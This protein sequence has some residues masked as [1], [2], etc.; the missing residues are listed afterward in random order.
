[1]LQFYEYWVRDYL[2]G[3]SLGGFDGF[4]EGLNDVLFKCGFS[5]LYAGNPYDWLFLY[6]SACTTED[7]TPLDRFRGIMAQD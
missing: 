6:C 5:P 2:D 7:Y 3:R 4:I 1:M